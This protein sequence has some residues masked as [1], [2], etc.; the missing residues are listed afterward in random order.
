MAHIRSSAQFKARVNSTQ[1]LVLGIAMQSRMDQY[2]SYPSPI[3]FIFLNQWHYAFR[4]SA[5]GKHVVGADFTL[6][7]LSSQISEPAYSP[8]TR[9]LALFDQHFNLLGQHQLNLT[10]SNLTFQANHDN[11]SIM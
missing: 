1:R 11:T 10:T 7:S 3:F 2:N 8:Q 4:R 5:D 6:S 9:T